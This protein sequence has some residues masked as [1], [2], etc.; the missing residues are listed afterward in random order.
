MYICII[1]KKYLFNQRNFI[2]FLI[3]FNFD[4]K[5]QFL[6]LLIC[7]LYN[8]RNKKHIYTQP[9]YRKIKKH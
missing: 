9:V 1:G 6:I 7:L 4:C 2:E 3:K 8:S 5:I